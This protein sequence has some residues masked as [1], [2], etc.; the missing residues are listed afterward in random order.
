MKWTR[1]LFEFRTV[2]LD[3]L[4]QLATSRTD[5]KAAV[6]FYVIVSFEGF[7][8]S[9]IGFGYGSRILACNQLRILSRAAA[10]RVKLLIAFGKV[11]EQYSFP[12]AG[13]FGHSPPPLFSGGRGSGQLQPCG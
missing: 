13:T 10:F 8:N 2:E 11:A 7:E 6:S 3:C 1:S 4:L 12:N 5:S 9:S